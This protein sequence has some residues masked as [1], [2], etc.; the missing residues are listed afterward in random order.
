MKYL[1]IPFMA[2]LALSGC[3]AASTVGQA[4]TGS[5]ATVAPGAMQSAEKA[6]TAAHALHEASAD[7]LT[8]AAKS[9]VCHAT[10]A[11]TAKAY[12]DQ[13]E[14]ILIAADSLVKLGDAVGIEAKIASA[15]A[16]ISQIQN[17]SAKGN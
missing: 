12:L 8:A 3:A 16:L 9:G 7:V 13:S 15:T 10:C 6:L 14:T 5:V 1:I 17:L 4:I 2:V 11:I